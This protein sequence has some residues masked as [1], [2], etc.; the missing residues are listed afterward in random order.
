MCFPLAH[1]TWSLRAIG[2]RM[3]WGGN[4]IVVLVVP[5]MFLHHLRVLVDE[6]LNVVLVDEPDKQACVAL[7]KANELVSGRSKHANY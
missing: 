2:W 5:P 3:P 6:L 7:R 4:L 1:G